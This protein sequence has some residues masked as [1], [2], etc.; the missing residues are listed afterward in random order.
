MSKKVQE[1]LEIVRAYLTKPTKR[2]EK[3]AHDALIEIAELSEKKRTRDAAGEALREIVKSDH[4]DFANTAMFSLNDLLGPG[5]ADLL[6]LLS[7][8]VSEYQDGDVFYL[9]G[10]RKIRGPEFRPEMVAFLE[11]TNRSMGSRSTVVEDLAEESGMPFDRDVL[12]V[13][14]PDLREEHLHVQE[15]KDW[16]NRGFADDDVSG[17]LDAFLE[18]LGLA[19]PSGYRT[20]LDSKSPPPSFEWDD[21]LWEL[22]SARQL[23]EPVEVDSQSLPTAE[24][25]KAYAATLEEVTGADFVEADTDEEFSF[26]RLAA[27]FVMGASEDGDLLFLDT[28]TKCSVWVYRH[29]GGSVEFAGKTFA[30]WKRKAKKS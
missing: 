15:I 26:R 23:L 13:I 29:D 4:Q 10:L 12:G 5:D 14:L 8:R 20:I 30:A 19:L 11:D 2:G 7:E 28:E 17:E 6:P 3:K 21:E 16:A 22:Y 25:L 27:G 18:R 9:R 24:Q 1:K